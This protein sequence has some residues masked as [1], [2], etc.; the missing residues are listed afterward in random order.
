MVN[1]FRQRDICVPV[2]T[3]IS[4]EGPDLDLVCISSGASDVNGMILALKSYYR[5]TGCFSSSH[6]VACQPAPSRVNDSPAAHTDV[7]W[8]QGSFQH[9]HE[10]LHLAAQGHHLLSVSH[11]VLVRKLVIKHD[12]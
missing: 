9:A 2:S 7:A 6:T 8:L 3:S 10:M 12:F 11:R 5:R 4:T 1:A